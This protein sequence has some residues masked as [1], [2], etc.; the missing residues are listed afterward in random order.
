MK[1]SFIIFYSWISDWP[2]NQNRKYIRNRLE[3]DLKKLKKEFSIEVAIESDTRG[4]DG[5]DTI[6]LSILHKIA[7]SDFFVGDVTS[8][9]WEN[10]KDGK[11][12]IPNPNVLFELGFA[13]S[14]IGWNRC[15]MVCN[16]HYGKLNGAPFDIRNHHIR[17]YLVGEKD[18]SLYT[19]LKEKIEGY[20]TL[21]KEWKSNKEKSFDAGVFASI[22]T[23]CSERELIDSIS[24][25]I[26]E[27]IYCREDFKWWDNRIYLYRHYQDCRFVDEEINN[28]Y[29]AFLSSLEKLCQ[30]ATTYNIDHPHNKS[31]T[32]D[33]P[34]WDRQYRYLIQD[35]LDTIRDEDRAFEQQQR[36]DAEFSVLARTV[37]PCYEAFR[38]IVRRKLLV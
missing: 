20:D 13:A 18:L 6:D 33:E 27:R 32:G 23:L 36:I 11:A 12:F 14:S 31:L 30:V 22:N 25:F 37:I 5:T 19:I 1:K 3:E 16:E 17:G 9:V 10:E 7:G 28:A 4:E 29:E 2:D 26:N 34:D 24:S 38:D 35:P 21:L 15:L 8:I